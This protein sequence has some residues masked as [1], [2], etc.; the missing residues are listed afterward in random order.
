MMY[1]MRW[2]EMHSLDELALNLSSP[3]LAAAVEWINIFV[4][5]VGVEKLEILEASER[6]KN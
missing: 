3:A 5:N 1:V 2:A 6:R 4:L